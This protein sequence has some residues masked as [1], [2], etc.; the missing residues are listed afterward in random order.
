MKIKYDVTKV[1]RGGG[2]QPDPGLYTAKVKKIVDKVAK[3]GN[4]MLE[5][6][7][8]ITNKTGPQKKFKGVSLRTWI[9]YADSDGNPAEA[10]ERRLAEFIDALGAKAKGTLDTDKAVGTEV[11]MKVDPDTYNGEYQARV[12]TLTAIPDDEEPEDDEEDDDDIE[13]EEDDD[14]SDDDDDAEDDDEDDEDED[15]DED[16]D[17]DEE[18]DDE[19]EDVDYNDLDLDELKALCKERGIKIKKGQKKKTLIGLLEEDDEEDDED[20]DPFS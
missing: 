8:Q 4:K 1:E 3:S 12:G 16:E 14:A 7:L 19:E 2:P 13:E 9:V 5:V 11:Q 6:T 10:S 20:D 18:E 15:E 17:D